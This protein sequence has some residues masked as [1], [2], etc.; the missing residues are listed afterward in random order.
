MVGRTTPPREPPPGPCTPRSVRA[1]ELC[2]PGPSERGVC[3]QTH[4]ERGQARAA[5]PLSARCA[6]TPRNVRS[7]LELSDCPRDVPSS[8]PSGPQDT[9]RGWTC[10]ICIYE[11]GPLKQGAGVP[12]T[13]TE[14]ASPLQLVGLLR[15]TGRVGGAAP[16]G[17][18]TEV[19]VQRTCPRGWKWRQQACKPR[20]GELE[21]GVTKATLGMM[22]LLLWVSQWFMYLQSRVGLNEGVNLRQTLRSWE[23]WS[24]LS[25]CM[26]PWFLGEPCL[27]TWTLAVGFSLPSGWRSVG[28][29]HTRLTSGGCGLQRAG[30]QGRRAGTTTLG[31][32]KA[33]QAR[34]SQ[35]PASLRPRCWRGC[36]GHE[37]WSVDLVGDCVPRAT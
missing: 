9:R 20:A 19:L 12:V 26:R 24:H 23:F 36:P 32:G 29:T 4:Q 30:G 14:D 5:Q 18:S 25:G 17:S 6:C 27:S 16:M 31:S 33:S 1:T 8:L 13:P 10:G 3:G 34:C 21:L 11:Q 7:A 28:G 22:G 2:S 37:R 35:R 15:W